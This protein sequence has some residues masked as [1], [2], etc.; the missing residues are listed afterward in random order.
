VRGIYRG[1]D[2]RATSTK[3]SAK[4]NEVIN[5]C[6]KSGDFVNLLHVQ[7]SAL[8]THIDI[9]GGSNAADRI[10][11]QR[12]W[13]DKCCRAVACVDPNNECD[14][15]N[16]GSM[17]GFLDGIDAIFGS[18]ILLDGLSVGHVARCD[19]GSWKEMHT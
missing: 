14:T 8:Y 1:F 11:S 13:H 18:Y 12:R 4:V 6:V 15:V 16:V 19:S 9:G 7:D 5:I 3:E 17:D 2:I 10:N